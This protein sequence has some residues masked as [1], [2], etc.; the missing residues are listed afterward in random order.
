MG[1]D[2]LILVIILVLLTGL[3]FLKK[4]VLLKNGKYKIVWSIPLVLFIIIIIMAILKGA[5]ILM[6][7]I[8]AVALVPNTWQQIKN[9][10]LSEKQNMAQHIPTIM[11]I[12]L[13]IIVLLK[14]L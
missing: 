8:L 2:I 9:F 14:V 12:A 6:Y 7:M 1:D 13:V 10:K 3:N 11:L 5:P 4:P